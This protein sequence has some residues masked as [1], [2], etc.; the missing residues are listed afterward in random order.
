MPGGGKGVGFGLFQLCRAAGCKP[1]LERERMMAKRDDRG[2]DA[3]DRLGCHGPVRKPVYQKHL[4][5][6]HR[7]QQIGG[8]R[9]Y[10]AVRGGKPIRELKMPERPVLLPPS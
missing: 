10:P 2:G 7:A 6:W 9:L 5:L 3:C 8:F 4:V 1:G